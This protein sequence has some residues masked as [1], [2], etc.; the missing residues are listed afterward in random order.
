MC[1]PDLRPPARLRRAEVLYR[2][3][4][5]RWGL[6]IGIGKAGVFADIDPWV[7]QDLYSMVGHGLQTQNPMRIA[8]GL[9]S[10]GIDP[11]HTCG[12]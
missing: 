8:E 6:Q 4:V 7:P 9:R 1:R 10:R 12:P 5:S 11:G 2:E 3:K